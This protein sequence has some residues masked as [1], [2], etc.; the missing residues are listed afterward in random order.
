MLYE[1]ITRPVNEAGILPA[2]SLSGAARSPQQQAAPR[3]H[4]PRDV[5]TREGILKHCNLEKA[6]ALG[7]LGESD[8]TSSTEILPDFTAWSNASP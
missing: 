8:S 6:A 4:L 7:E 3:A 2:S 5:E 1:V